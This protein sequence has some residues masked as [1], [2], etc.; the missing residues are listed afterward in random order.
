MPSA[1]CDLDR[2]G[3]VTDEKTLLI[4]AIQELHSHFRSQL[5]I[6]TYN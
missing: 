2:E 1:H 3:W 6:F 4:K 5:L